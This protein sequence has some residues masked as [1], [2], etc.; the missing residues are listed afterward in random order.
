MVS[1]VLALALAPLE[2]RY[3]L[4]A[5]PGASAVELGASSGSSASRAGAAAKAS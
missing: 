5:P 3:H 2:V 1:S 4:S